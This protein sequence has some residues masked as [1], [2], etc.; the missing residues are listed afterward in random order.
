MTQSNINKKKVLVVEDEM[1]LGKLCVRILTLEGHDVDLAANGKTAQAMV[2]NTHYDICLSDI[3]TPGMN[4][5]DLYKY[6]LE[7]HPSLAEK[8]LF[9]TGDI[10]NKSITTFLKE[11]NVRYILKPFT[12]AELNAAISEL[13]K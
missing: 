1:V 10:M 5:M 7:K 8:T 11:N 2:E 12:H 3:R 4:G 6:F 13:V 9:M